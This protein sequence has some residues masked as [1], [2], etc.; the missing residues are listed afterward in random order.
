MK[1][2]GI[3]S[4]S[5]LYFPELG[6]N[7]ER[8]RVFLFSP[9]AGKYGPENSKYGNF[10]RSEMWLQFAIF[11]PWNVPWNWIAFSQNYFVTLLHNK[12]TSL[13][14]FVTLHYFDD[15]QTRPLRQMLLFLWNNSLTVQKLQTELCI[16]LI[17][18]T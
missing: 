13:D 2:V 17:L 9:K 3:W 14:Y 6:L 18:V 8:Y 10:L 1:S 12:F 16:C 5:R 7:T 15:L 11:N 4:F